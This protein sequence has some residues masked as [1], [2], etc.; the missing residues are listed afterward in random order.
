MSRTIIIIAIAAAA[1][2]TLGAC[3]PVFDDVTLY[4]AP[5]SQQGL[6]CTNTCSTT[7]N[8]C[9]MNRAQQVDA[10]TQRVNDH[11][12]TLEAKH[13]L[14]TANARARC[15]CDGES[16]LPGSLN[17]VWK[18]CGV[19]ARGLLTNRC[20]QRAMNCA[21]AYNTCHMSCGGS[22]RTE[23]RCVNRCEKLQNAS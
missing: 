17:C 21:T 16:C 6:I 10:C 3:G 13:N 14:C 22:V 9:E 2:S 12:A 5:T 1:L 18:A 8:Y 19:V 23:R 11:N 7:R 15:G 20:E 4:T